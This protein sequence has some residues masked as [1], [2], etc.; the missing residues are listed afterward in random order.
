MKICVAKERRAD[1]RRV[2]AS[3][4]TVKRLV[5]MGHEVIVESGAG[6]GSAFPDA[7]YAAQGA[8]IAPDAAAALGA[9]DIVLKVQRPLRAGEDAVDE[10][11][12]MKR[13]AVL[14]GLLQPLQQP[15]DVAAYA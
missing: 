5:G 4:D 2:A 11:A 3:P 6:A 9:G 14:V 15:A 8:T 13:G 10:L 7:A 12:L 1:E